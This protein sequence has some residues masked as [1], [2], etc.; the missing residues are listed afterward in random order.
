MKSFILNLLKTILKVSLY[1]IVVLI[2]LVALFGG[3]L[4]FDYYMEGLGELFVA[5]CLVTFFLLMV[6]FSYRKD[7]PK[8]ERSAKKVGNLILKDIKGSFVEIKFLS[9]AIGI[10]ILCLLALLVVIVLFI[11]F[12]WLIS[13]LSATTIIIILLILIL[14]K[15]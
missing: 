10:I 2:L 11:L 6:F 3:M 4:L 7:L 15:K 14:L 9:R 5:L 13:T 1:T 12:G 8:G